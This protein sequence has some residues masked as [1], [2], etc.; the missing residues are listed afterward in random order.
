MANIAAGDVTYLVLKQRK[1][2]SSQNSNLVRLSFGDE[3]LEYPA[4]GIP[5]S[6]GKLGCPTY[7][8]SMVIVDQGTS[9]YKFQY[10][11]SAKKLVM[12]QAPAQTHTHDLKIIGGQAAASTDAVSAKTLTL[13]KEAAT[14]ITVA[15][16]DSATLGGVV[17]STL[18]AAALAE[19][20]TIAIAAQI[21]EVEVIGY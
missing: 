12:L 7:V 21:I 4:G 9:G 8:E 6:I 19:A 5:I 20:S 14:D 13:G 11:Q 15:G 2:A 10:D 3:I 18:A 17:S 16:D 1:N